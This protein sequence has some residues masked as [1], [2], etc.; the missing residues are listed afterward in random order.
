MMRALLDTDVV[1][2]ALL[3]RAPFVVDSYGLWQACTA[4]RLEGWISAITPIN[5]FYIARKQVGADRA[6]QH[7]ADLLTAFQ[8]L[9]ID[10][11]ALRTAH[12]LPMDDF[13]DAVQAASAAAAGLDALVTRNTRDYSAAPLPILT[14]AEALARLASAEQ[15]PMAP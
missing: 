3:R 1:L 7:V 4:G 9:P 10:A 13:E 2:D 11:A 8:V 15:P 6:R 12:A 14:P 5:V